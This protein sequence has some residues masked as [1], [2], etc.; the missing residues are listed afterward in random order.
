MNTKDKLE[1]L[2]RAI[3]RIIHEEEVHFEGKEYNTWEVKITR[4]RLRLLVR[5]ELGITDPH[6]IR[7]WIETLQTTVLSPNS[8]TQLS[9]IKGIVKPTNET[10]YIVNEDKLKKILTTPSLTTLENF[11]KPDGMVQEEETVNLK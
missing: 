4:L 1:K 6:T 10:M 8:T 2:H 5:V 3:D 7:S 9:A 11:N